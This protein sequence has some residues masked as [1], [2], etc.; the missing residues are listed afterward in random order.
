MKLFKLSSKEALYLMAAILWAS[1]IV[2]NSDQYH[3]LSL[4]FLGV[5]IIFM[6]V[7]SGGYFEAIFLHFS[8]SP[9]PLLSAACM[10]AV[11]C[12][13]ITFL[14][15]NPPVA[16]GTGVVVLFVMYLFWRAQYYVLPLAKYNR[17]TSAKD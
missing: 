5:S 11:Y 3:E 16:P 9:R 14:G 1:A 4:Y 7:L 8:G 15:R 2:S 10:V 17:T 12:F 13:I 6:S